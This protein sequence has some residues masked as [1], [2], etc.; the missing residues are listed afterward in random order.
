MKKYNSVLTVI[1][2]MIVLFTAGFACNNMGGSPVPNSS[3]PLPGSMNAAMSPTP[4]APKDISGTYEVTGTNEGG[5]GNYKGAL[6]VTDRDEVYQFS[7]KSGTHSYDGVGVQTDNSVAAAFANGTDGT[8]CGVVLYKIGSDGSLDGK[9]GYWGVNQSEK[10]SATRTSGTGL[11]GEYDVS[12][13]NPKGASYTGTLSVKPSG[14]GFEFTWNEAKLTGFGIK[15]GDKVAVGVGGKQC[16]FV[17]YEVGSDGTMNGKW[18]SVGSTTVGTET[19]KK[20]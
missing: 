18:G 10:E 16:G 11:E 4:S 12:G 8:G 9:A 3:K 17:S 6:L 13:T 7:W 15:Q 14:S 2:V 19:A 5:G 20:K 1:L